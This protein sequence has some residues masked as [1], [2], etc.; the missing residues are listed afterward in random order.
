[1]AVDYSAYY[2]QALKQAQKQDGAYQAERRALAAE[3]QS[4]Q[5]A[6]AE[7]QGQLLQQQYQQGAQKAEGDYRAA[8]DRNAVEQAVQQ[9]RLQETLA[10]MGLTDSGLSR[11][12]HTA[13]ALQRSKADADTRLARQ[14]TMD[15]LQSELMRG[16]AEL[17]AQ[18]AGQQNEAAQHA[19]QDIA[20]N[21][22]KLEQA[23]REQ[24]QSAYDAAV[25]EQQRIDENKS[26]EAVRIEQLRLQQQDRQRELEENRQLLYLRCLALGWTEADAWQYA[27][28]KFPV[29]STLSDIKWR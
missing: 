8:L 9:Q 28:E 16:K 29:G 22:Q 12:Q 1:M 25:R 20:A 13:L 7:L 19:L 17:A 23:A 27:L 18:T 6:A 15:G 4:L 5:Q 14:Q 24:A 3:Q 2:Q 10:N 21:R 11:S 26:D